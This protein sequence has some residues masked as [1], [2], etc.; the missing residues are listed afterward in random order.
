MS[1][2]VAVPVDKYDFIVETLCMRAEDALL[3]NCQST[4]TVIIKNRKTLQLFASFTRLKCKI[5]V[6]TANYNTYI[7]NLVF[8][9]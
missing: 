5:K 6:I 1:Q 7:I 2:N 8:Q 4:A 3:Y 9:K